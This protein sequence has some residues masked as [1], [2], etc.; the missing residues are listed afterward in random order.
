MRKIQNTKSKT[1]SRLGIFLIGMSVISF[2]IFYVV[3]MISNQGYHYIDIDTL[4]FVQDQEIPENAPVAVIDT[5]LGEIRAVLYPEY[6][7]ETV[8]QFIT[9]AESGYYDNTYVF[10]AKNDVYFAAGSID[11]LGSLPENTPESQERLPQE[12]H[13]NLWTFRGALC[14]VNTASDTSFTKRLFKTETYYT[15]SRF[16]LLNSVD[17]S[18]PEFLEQFREAS[19]SEELADLF[20]EKGGVPNFAQQMTV[21]GQVYQ[22]FDVIQE[23][24]AAQLQEENTQGYTPP[25][26]DILIRSVR[27]SE[28]ISEN[29]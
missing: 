27:I 3:T 29:S 28:Y 21:F 19:G 25:A 4:E 13:Q 8:S 2:I 7:P 10:E 6:A 5:S 24:C 15:G 11:N 14:A 22:G 9:L 17:F 1:L 18:D 23:I 26:E 16:M 12:L 20:I